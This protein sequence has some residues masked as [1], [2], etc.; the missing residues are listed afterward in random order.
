MQLYSVETKTS[1]GSVAAA[2]GEALR[3]PRRQVKR[4]SY[5]ACEWDIS[6][7]ADQMRR[8]AQSKA[9]RSW[10]TRD[11]KLNCG[12]KKEKRRKEEKKVTEGIIPVLLERWISGFLN[13]SQP[14][15]CAAVATP[16][17][18]LP[19]KTLKSFIQLNLIEE[20][21]KEAPSIQGPSVRRCP[22]QTLNVSPTHREWGRFCR[23]E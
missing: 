20:E 13:S 8:W 1:Q 5:N 10:T 4:I 23:R 19:K 12:R 18:S 22:P 15:P 16:L 2:A 9:P 7:P 11:W 17:Q 6:S 21:K 14:L 3:E